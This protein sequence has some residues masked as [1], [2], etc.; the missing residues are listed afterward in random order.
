LKIAQCAANSFYLSDLVLYVGY[1]RGGCYGIITK[2]KTHTGYLLQSL[3]FRWK[4]VLVWGQETLVSI[5]YLS[6]CVSAVHSSVVSVRMM[7][8]G[9]FRG[10]EVVRR[11]LFQVTAVVLVHSV[12]DAECEGLYGIPGYFH[13]AHH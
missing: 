13:A 5:S 12:P 7:G 6:Y 4:F 11:Q 2:A 1:C 9:G 10:S 8:S 3:S